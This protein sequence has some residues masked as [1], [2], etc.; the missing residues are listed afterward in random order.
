MCH[1]FAS[2]LAMGLIWC[3]S[4]AAL[5]LLWICYGFGKVCVCC[6]LFLCVKAGDDENDDDDDADDD[7][8]DSDEDDHDDDN[9]DKCG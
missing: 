9:D 8:D 1:G 7:S 6:E 5:V 2:G 4:S 3:C